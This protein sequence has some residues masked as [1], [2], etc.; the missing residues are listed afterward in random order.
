MVGH[1]HRHRRPLLRFHRRY[2]LHHVEAWVELLAVGQLHADAVGQHPVGQDLALSVGPGPPC[3]SRR[4]ACHAE[5]VARYPVPACR[6]V[7]QTSSHGVQMEVVAMHWGLQ[8][9][10]EESMVDAAACR[11]ARAT[12]RAAPRDKHPQDFVRESSTS[13]L[14]QR[15]LVASQVARP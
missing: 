13:K 1:H 2:Q 8:A 7:G 6:V 15:G 11:Q 3:L 4:A 12:G 9:L 14:H 5:A 10:A